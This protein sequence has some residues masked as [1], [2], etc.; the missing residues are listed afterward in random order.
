MWA[1]TICVTLKYAPLSLLLICSILAN[2]LP[3][4]LWFHMLLSWNCYLGVSI[5]IPG[6]GNVV[7]WST[8]GLYFLLM[9]TYKTC[10][11]CI[12]DSHHVQFYKST[13]LWL[14]ID[15]HLCADGVH[16]NPMGM[17][18]QARNYRGAFMKAYPFP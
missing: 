10:V 16:L 2:I 13:G 11:T 9:G 6:M 1:Q 7:F 4:I 18:K 5:G 8:T 17:A 15:K 12:Y 3:Y 14:D